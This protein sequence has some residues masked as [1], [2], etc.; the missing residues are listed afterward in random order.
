MQTLDNEAGY[1]KITNNTSISKSGNYFEINNVLPEDATDN[2]E[3]IA[4]FCKR[5]TTSLAYMVDGEA[6]FVTGRRYLAVK[7]PYSTTEEALNALTSINAE[8][9]WKNPTA[10]TIP[11]DSLS[12][13]TQ[14]GV[15]NLWA[16]SGDI[17]VK[18]LDKIIQG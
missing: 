14:E 7:L 10:T 15:N 5:T 6:R 17:T 8:I 1:Y 13:A 18:A 2:Y 11:Q 12:I 4:S 3:F 16:D 9:T